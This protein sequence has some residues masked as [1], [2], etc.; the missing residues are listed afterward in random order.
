MSLR[1]IRAG[2]LALFV[3]AAGIL[4]SACGSGSPEHSSQSTTS[5][6]AHAPSPVVASSAPPCSASQL[7]AQYRGSQ[8]EA[9][10]WASSFWVANTSPIPCAMGSTVAV[11]LLGSGADSRT[12]SHLVDSP[13][14]LS[15]NA[16][17]PPPG[18]NPQKGQTLAAVGVSW[19]TEPNAVSDL[20]GTGVTCPQPLFQAQSARITFGNEQTLNVDSLTTS[21]PPLSRIPPICGP[22]TYLWD[23]SPLTAPPAP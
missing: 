22:T 11:K 2:R 9:G 23:V 1:W 3:M 17:I 14:R 7:V 21:Q 6:P 8:G 5:A 10:N 18:Q 16:R 4:A 19:P 12:A 13:I 20:G 15:A